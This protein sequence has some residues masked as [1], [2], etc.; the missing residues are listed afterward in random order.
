[1]DVVALFQ[2][3]VTHAVATLGTATTPDHAE[4]LFRNAPDVYFCFDGDNAG[5]KAATRA[6]E[7]VLPRMRDGRQAFFLFLPEGEDPDTLVRSEGA[8]GL[9]ARLQQATPLSQ[10]LFDSLAADDVNLSTLDGTARLA[11]RAKP[12][13]AQIPDGAFGDLMRQRLTRSEEHTSELKS[14]LRISYA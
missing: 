8:T 4:L 11:E 6:M 1:M 3:G 14:L 12:M 13:L 2:H 5:R 10:F 7:S 9:D